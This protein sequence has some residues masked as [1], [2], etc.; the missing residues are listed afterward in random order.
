MINVENNEP[1]PL[2][3]AFPTVG[4]PSKTTHEHRKELIEATTYIDEAIYNNRYKQTDTKTTIAKVYHN[5]CCY[6]ELFVRTSTGHIEHYRPKSI[7]WWL[8]YSW[9]NLLFICPTCNSIKRN[10]FE[11][12]GE[13]VSYD[14]NSLNNIHNL[15]NTY[16]ELEKPSL[17]H[18]ECDTFEGM[19]IFQRNGKMDSNVHRGQYT[20]KTL[21]LD[22]HDLRD[23]R[24]KLI[25]DIE[26]KIN[27]LSFLYQDDVSGLQKHLLWIIEEFVKDANNQEE[28]FIAFRK[29]FIQN[30]LTDFIAEIFM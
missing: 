2:S 15:R 11:I 9:D 17:L 21:E 10:K 13:K 19:W 12:R 23:K 5:K 27:S 1:I 24:A 28:E 4:Q 8:A 29:Y 18:P 3:L 7:Y 6:C 26:G 14:E 22:A 25:N 16:N 30:L 20:I